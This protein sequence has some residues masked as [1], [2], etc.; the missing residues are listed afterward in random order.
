M[1]RYT[2]RD[3]IRWS[4]P[5]PTPGEE[6]VAN[7]HPDFVD[8]TPVSDAAAVATRSKWDALLP[9]GTVPLIT[10]RDRYDEEDDAC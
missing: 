10:E 7:A 6:Q 8:L 4:G 5:Q 1:S 9:G 3:R 2:R